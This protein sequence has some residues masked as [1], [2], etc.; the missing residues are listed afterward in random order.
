VRRPV[1]AAGVVGP[2]DEWD[3]SFK[4]GGVIARVAVREGEAIRKGQFLA[5][6][7]ATEVEAGAR[8]TKAGLVKAERDLERAKTLRA[9]EAVP[10]LVGDDAETAVAVAR[11]ALDGALFNLRRTVLVAPDD[12]WVDARMAEPG[13]VVSAGRPVLH[14]SGRGRGFVLRAQVPE[15]DVLDLSVGDA[16]TVSIDARPGTEIPGRIVEL[17]RS[18]SRGTGT[19][20]VVVG[21]EPPQH[22]GLLAGLTAKVAI[23]RMVPAGATVPLAAVQEGDGEL[24][25][26]FAVENDHAR[27]VPVRIAFLQ[28]ALAVLETDLAGVERVITEGAARVADGDR[29]QLLP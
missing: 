29:V 1:R 8:Q 12:G 18:A 19:F 24:G 28:G 17:G 14:V 10:K 15:R 11:A 21:L 4:V 2:R 20:Q 5:L 3:L 22:L 27:R 26:V 6:L 25:A 7:D 9:S 13:E 16:A 23:E